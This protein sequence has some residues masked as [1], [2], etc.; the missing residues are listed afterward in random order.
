M[1]GITTNRLVRSGVVPLGATPRVAG[2]SR[3]GA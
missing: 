1:T 2:A 3:S